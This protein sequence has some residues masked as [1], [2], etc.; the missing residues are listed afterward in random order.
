M[1]EELG[2][3]L[4][5]NS[6]LAMK[7]EIR[8]C[9]ILIRHNNTIICT[10]NIGAVKDSLLLR[11]I[12]KIL[13]VILIKL[14]KQRLILSQQNNARMLILLVETWC[15]DK[16]APQSATVQIKELHIHYLN[17]NNN[18]GLNM[19]LIISY[20]GLRNRFSNARLVSWQNDR[21]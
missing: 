1:W 21:R 14:S 4:T 7:L 15:I 11:T 17:N 18:N 12:L 10:Y 2:F 8:D 16:V 6:N 5:Y 19:E 3:Y 20:V 9:V 13:S